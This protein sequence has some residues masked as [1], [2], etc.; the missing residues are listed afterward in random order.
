MNDATRMLK[1][2]KSRDEFKRKQKDLDKSFYCCDMD[3]L[4]INK[5]PPAILAVI[6][7]KQVSDLI[8]FSEVIA[9][10]HLRDMDLTVLIVQ[11]D[12]E[13]GEFVISEYIAGDWRPR[14]P[15]TQINCIAE[16]FNWD[17]YEGWQR[18]F[19]DKQIKKLNDQIKEST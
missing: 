18:A 13:T 11:G 7:Y 4:F 2:S 1:G 8:T 9:Y 6:D 12:F 3:L 10:N 15:V 5:N 19:R 16:T 14:P 17:E